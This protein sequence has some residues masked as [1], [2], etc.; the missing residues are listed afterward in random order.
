MGYLTL[1]SFF[2]EQ[3]ENLNCDNTTKAY[4]VG[5]LSKFKNSSADYSKDSI[6]LLFAKAKHNQDFYI[7]Q[8]IGD[9][10]FYCNVWFP[11]YFNNA[12]PEY[13]YSVGQLS[14]YACYRLIKKQWTT[15]EV[16]ADQ[17]SDLSL[18]ARNIL[19]EKHLI[20]IY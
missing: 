11:E 13:Y 16:L 12:V 8:N 5:I 10:I 1:N 15:Y 7:F 17:F 3:L 9:F 20:R 14:Y 2:N 19:K 6:T 18:E 4:I